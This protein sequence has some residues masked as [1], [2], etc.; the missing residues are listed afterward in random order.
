M[1]KKFLAVCAIL[2]MCV[3]LV[4]CGGAGSGNDTAADSGGAKDGD[5]VK[6]DYTGKLEDGTVFDS[7]ETEGRTPLEFTV[8]AGEMI[9]G[10]D[11]GVVGMKVGEKKTLTLPPEEAYGEAGIEG[12]IPPNATLTF[13]VTMVEITPAA[14][15]Q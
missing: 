12:V 3:A 14:A 9:P 6:V 8:G 1:V 13:D 5:T 2:L 7:S 4:A 11:K 15:P 10:F